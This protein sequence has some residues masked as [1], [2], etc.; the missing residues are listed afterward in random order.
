MRG[1]SLELAGAAPDRPPA[2]MLPVF[3]PVEARRQA[4][5]Y[6]ATFYPGQA[7]ELRELKIS[8]SSPPCH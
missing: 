2:A 3:E 1:A 4:E 8:A 6:V 7:F 5:E